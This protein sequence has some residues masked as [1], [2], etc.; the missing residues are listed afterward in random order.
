MTFFPEP[1]HVYFVAKEIGD[2]GDVGGKACK[3]QIH[4][5]VGEDF[6]KVVGD[7]QGLETEAKIAGY[8]YAVFTDHGHAGTAI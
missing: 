5:A 1:I 6:R 8:S 4:V 3:A 2:S 7:G